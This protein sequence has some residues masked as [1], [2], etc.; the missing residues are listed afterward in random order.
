VHDKF[1]SRFIF[2]FNDLQ[3]RKKIYTSFNNTRN[4]TGRFMQMPVAEKSE[5]DISILM[6]TGTAA[7]SSEIEFLDDLTARELDED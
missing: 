4:S 1:C 6:K 3:R 5:I 2:I 7:L